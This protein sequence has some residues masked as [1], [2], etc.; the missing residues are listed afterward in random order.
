MIIDFHGSGGNPEEAEDTYFDS[1][2]KRSHLLQNS[3]N[4]KQNL[5][6]GTPRV[7]YRDQYGGRIGPWALALKF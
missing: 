5:R 4:F 2:M 1:S 3:L 7:L 6:D